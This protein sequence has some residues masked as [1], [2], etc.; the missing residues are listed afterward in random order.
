MFIASATRTGGHGAAGMIEI[1]C[2]QH[3]GHQA[4]F[5]EI[6]SRSGVATYADLI[7]LMHLIDE[8]SGYTDEP[9][10]AGKFR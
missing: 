6:G 3:S 5:S 10:I 4:E 1:M 7:L 8:L 2:G 9:K